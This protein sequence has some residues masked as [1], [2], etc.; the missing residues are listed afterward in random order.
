MSSTKKGSGAQSLVT[1]ADVKLC[2]LCGTLNH[3]KNVECYTCGWRGV[4]D[5]DSRLV[6]IA[7]ERLYSQFETVQQC[8]VSATRSFSVDE[9]GVA[10]HTHPVRR[11]WEGVKAWF[12][13]Q[14]SRHGIAAGTRQHPF[15]HN[16]LGV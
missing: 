1:E 11:W 5:R 16:E 15:P 8:H 9:L 13:Q 2:A 7:W 4:F 3:V 12:A 6:H 14:R 10:V